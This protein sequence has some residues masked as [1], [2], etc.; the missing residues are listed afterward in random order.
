MVIYKVIYAKQALKDAKKLS[1]ASLDTKAKE[2]I[3]LIKINPLQN[4]PPPIKN[5]LAI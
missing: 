4:P 1:E 3:E 5:L 2:L